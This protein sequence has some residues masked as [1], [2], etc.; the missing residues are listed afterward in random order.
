VENDMP[1]LMDRLREI[2][3]DEKCQPSPLL[4]T[5]AEINE[6]KLIVTTN[7][8]RLM[9]R[10]LDD[11]MRAYK[12]VVQPIG[13]FDVG[14]HPE[15]KGLLDELVEYDDL[16]LYKIHGTFQDGGTS[17][18]IITEEDY[19]EFLTVASMKDRG[20]PAPIA[21]KLVDSTLLF[22]G[23]G[24]E[25]WDFRVI[26]HALIGKLPPREHRKSFAIQRTPSE[27]W[28]KYWGHRGV[29]IYE[30]DIY[31]FANELAQRYKPRAGAAG[32]TD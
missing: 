23:Y 1:Y 30:S 31:Q 7:Y 5:L 17:A 12:T 3:P 32:H 25:D 21:D 16:I 10:A 18:L 22:L 11:A 20:V 28:G 19:I 24:L 26:F 27:F 4:R 9:E 2:L 6:L 13:G 29:E 14:K 15:L 8:D